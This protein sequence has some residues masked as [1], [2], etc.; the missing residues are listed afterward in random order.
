MTTIYFP[1]TNFFLEFR[2]ASE[3]PWKDLLADCPNTIELLIPAAVV[4][5]LG[6]HKRKSDGRKA[7][8][9][10]DVS[11]EIRKADLDSSGRLVVREKEPRVLLGSPPFLA[12]DYSKWPVLDRTNLDHQIAAQV[13]TYIAEVGPACILTDDTNLV[14]TARAV[15]VPVLYLP[16]SWELPPEPDA[17][18]KKIAKLETEVRQLKNARS[19]VDI[20]VLTPE[21]DAIVDELSMR[22]K[23]Y[24]RIEGVVD[25]V[26]AKVEAVFPMETEFPQ[27]REEDKPAI[28]FTGDLVT[29]ASLRNLGMPWVPQA[30]RTSRIIKKRTIRAG[31]P[32]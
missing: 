3:L 12:I 14:Q 27:M 1:D 5:E 23:D 6:G 13:A 15:I 9:A 24:G 21:R 25:R 20:Q 32:R 4:T 7:R 22:L 10:R 29:L 11:A 28:K 18:A 17:Q 8:R 2:K 19:D 30:R 26:V 16:E 31:Y